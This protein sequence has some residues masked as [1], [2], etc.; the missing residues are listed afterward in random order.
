MD[1]QRTR[2]LPN[3]KPKPGYYHHRKHDPAKGL[4][5]YAYFVMGTGRHTEDGSFGISYFP[6]YEGHDEYLGGADYPHRPFD[7]FIDGRFTE[8]TDPKDIAELRRAR[9]AMWPEIFG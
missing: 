6:L 7:M 8:I 1:T 9:D 4:R 3:E 2:V 5:D